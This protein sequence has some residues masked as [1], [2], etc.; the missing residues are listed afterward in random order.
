M[1][2]PD[3]K[4]IRLKRLYPNAAYRATT[5]VV[6]LPLPRVEGGGVGAARVRDVE[7]IQ[8][9][10]D[11]MLSLDGKPSRSVLLEQTVGV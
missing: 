4:Q 8:Y 2:L 6:Q 3:S 10:A 9:I 5:G 11:L 7:L 1:E